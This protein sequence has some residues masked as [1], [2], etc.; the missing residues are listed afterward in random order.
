MRVLSP[1][2]LASTLAVI[3]SGIALAV[4]GPAPAV[5]LR[6]HLISF[7][8]GHSPSPEAPTRVT[9][10]QD[11]ALAGLEAETGKRRL[12]LIREAIDL[13]LESRHKLAG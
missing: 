12:E 7:T 11:A 1:L 8:G 13:L 10:R 5:L 6:I 4:T 3:A 2:L 9:A